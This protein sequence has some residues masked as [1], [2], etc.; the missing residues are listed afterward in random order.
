[1]EP[2]SDPAAPPAAEAAGV[3]P[4]AGR[5]DRHRRRDRRRS[6]LTSSSTCPPTRPPLPD[7]T[8][9]GP[10]TST[11]W[12][13]PGRWSRRL[14][15]S[16][17]NDLRHR[18]ASW[19][20]EDPSTGRRF[21]WP[22]LIATTIPTAL[23]VGTTIN[24]GLGRQGARSPAP[25]RSPLAEAMAVHGVDARAMPRLVTALVGSI[26]VAGYH[27]RPHPRTGRRLRAAGPSAHA[28]HGS[29]QVAGV[30][31]AQTLPRLQSTSSSQVVAP[32]RGGGSTGAG[33]ALLTPEADARRRAVV[34]RHCTR[35]HR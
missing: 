22:P 29:L 21:A 33:R 11:P 17:A 30:E 4:R 9:P 13:W 18:L 12:R 7:F 26:S 28:R 5:L 16:A 35:R 23:M 20:G 34:P 10:G 19:F 6:G 24:D 3:P 32:D 15:T 27:L 1:M 8:T 31:L 14:S 2:I 25:V